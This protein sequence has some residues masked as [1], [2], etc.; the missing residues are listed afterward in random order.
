VVRAM[1]GLAGRS[2]ALVMLVLS[3]AQ[4]QSGSSVEA[5]ANDEQALAMARADGHRRLIG[6]AL[7]NLGFIRYLK[8]RHAE[9][10]SAS[11]QGL[12]VF[13]EVGQIQKQGTAL[14]NLALAREALGRIDEAQADYEAALAISGWSRTGATWVSA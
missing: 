7:G 3:A 2:M 10:E 14:H 4:E 1:P 9:S 6:D 5:R 12:Q 11:L 13:R 8:G